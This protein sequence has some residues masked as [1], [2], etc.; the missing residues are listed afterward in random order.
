[1]KYSNKTLA[2]LC[3]ALSDAVSTHAEMER[4]FLQHGLSY[5]QFSGGLGPRCNALVMKLRQLDDGDAALTYLIEYVLGR[6]GAGCPASDRLLQSLRVDGFEWDDRKLLPTTPTPAALGPE[7]SQLEL[8]LGELGLRVAAQHYRQAHESF[9]ASNWEAANGQLR[10]FME[11][12]LIE[13][14]KRET[15]MARCDASAALQDLR[16]KAFFDDAEWQMVK[17]FWQGIQ[18]KGPHRGLSDQQEALFRLHVATA[19]ARYAVHKSRASR[20]SA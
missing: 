4:V 10:S 5:D 2:E 20:G 12:F 9:V 6:R 18:D 11:D 3:R 13:L 19:V 8:E 1:M 7:L 14:G 16:S 17:G 15:P